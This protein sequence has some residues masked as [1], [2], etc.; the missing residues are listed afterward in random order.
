MHHCSSS[1]I[2]WILQFLVGISTRATIL[3]LCIEGIWLIFEDRLPIVIYTRHFVL[4]AAKFERCVL[5]DMK[6]KGTG[7]SPTLSIYIMSISTLLSSSISPCVCL[8]LPDGSVHFGKEVFWWRIAVEA[9]LRGID[10]MVSIAWLPHQ[11]FHAF[12]D[13][14]IPVFYSELVIVIPSHILQSV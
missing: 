11:P 5:S 7:V 4:L 1:R 14:S 12:H 2:W 6:I 8:P 3:T 9:T 13:V 10:D